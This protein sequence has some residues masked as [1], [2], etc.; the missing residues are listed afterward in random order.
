MLDYH[1]YW[2][3]GKRNPKFDD[4]SN[5]ILNFKKGKNID[6]VGE[7]FYKNLC[8]IIQNPD[9]CLL[10][11]P[12]HDGAESSMQ[13]V[14]M[15]L[16]ENYGVITYP[17]A[18]GR[19]HPIEKLSTGGTRNVNIIWE[20]LELTEEPKEANIF[21]LDDITTSGNSLFA[22]ESFLKSNIF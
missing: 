4:T 15:Y 9:V 19:K 6:T 13:K 12:S 21:L 11:M 18:L 7:L 8:E 3:N 14:L 2:K 20:S 10:T 16:S 5:K 1:P 17:Y 22:A